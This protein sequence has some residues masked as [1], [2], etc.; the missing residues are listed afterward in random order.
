[1]LFAVIESQGQIS[2]G[3]C[4]NADYPWNDRCRA[5]IIDKAKVGPY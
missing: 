3:R 5:A 2:P 1:M 4:Y